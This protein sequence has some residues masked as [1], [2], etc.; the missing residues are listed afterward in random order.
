MAAWPL[1]SVKGRGGEITQEDVRNLAQ[2]ADAFPKDR[3]QGTSFFQR[4]RHSQSTRSRAAAKI[5]LEG[6]VFPKLR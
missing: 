1:Q 4:R 5:P 6:N 2:V 3:I